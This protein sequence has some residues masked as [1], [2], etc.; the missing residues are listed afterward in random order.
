MDKELITTLG[1]DAEKDLKSLLEDLE[2][3]QYEF[4]ERLETTKD[5][6]RREELNSLLSRIDEAIGLIKDELAA[7]DSAIILDTGAAVEKA[8]EKKKQEKEKKK[9]EEAQ[10][11]EKVQAIKNKEDVRVKQDVQPVDDTSVQPIPVAA[12]PVGSDLHQGL[13]FYHTQNYTAAFPIFKKLAEENNAAAQYMLACMYYRGEGTDADCERAEFWM[14]KAADNGDSV[15]QY[16]YAVILLSDSNR[17]E[18]RTARGMRYLKLSAN[19]DNRDA[20]TRFV[21]LVDSNVGGISEIKAAQ[22][23]CEKL[24]SLTEDSYDRQRFE[25]IA[26]QLK[27]RY[28]AA[29]RRR[30]GT[31]ASSVVSL[32]GALILMVATVFIFM[33]YHGEYLR[34]LPL[35]EKL[36]ADVLDE[37]CGHWYTGDT[38]TDLLAAKNVLILVAIGWMFKGA[39]CKYRRNKL[40][41]AVVWVGCFLRYAA[42][43][44]HFILCNMSDVGVMTNFMINAVGIAAAILVGRLLGVILSKILSTNY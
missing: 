24:M 38:Y 21:L 33:G 39:G 8:S 43:V 9:A 28:K 34:A 37:L 40:A 4:F 16:D 2:S 18:L 11:S 32:I 36:P 3:K 35:A 29:R 20:M 41:A 19:Q 10:L 26:K 12:T 27:R 17:D 42:I 31:A 13:Q 15:A 1:L 14:N 44:G 30:F 22:T 23:Y 6:N 5:E 25:V 7:V